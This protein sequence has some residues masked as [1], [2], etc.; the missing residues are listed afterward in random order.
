MRP[1]RHAA[2]DAAIISAPATG[3]GGN[4]P[5]GA[6]A[7]C[8][9]CALQRLRSDATRSPRHVT[10]RNQVLALV[11]RQRRREVAL[12]RPRAGGQLR[13]HLR[14]PDRRDE[15]AIGQ[16][17]RDDPDQADR[18]QSPQR[19]DSRLNLLTHA[20]LDPDRPG[21]THERRARPTRPGLRAAPRPM[22][23]HHL[24]V[25]VHPFADRD[26]LADLERRV[27]AELDPPLNLDGRQPTVVRVRPS[28]L[29]RRLAAA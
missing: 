10:T 19:P 20:R 26:A 28:E 11:G 25:A 17:G 27:L 23:A 6:R 5:G 16:G 7:H 21:A 9:R 13:T 4:R 8:S 3:P 15:M 29:R 1:Q 24:D 22:D 14:G 18:Q 12:G 2:R